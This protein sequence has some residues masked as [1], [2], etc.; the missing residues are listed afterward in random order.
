MLLKADPRYLQYGSYLSRT[1]RNHPI[2]NIAGLDF[3]PH[4]AIHR[5]LAPEALPSPG[6]LILSRSRAKWP[7]ISRG[8]ALSWLSLSERERARHYPNRALAKR[9]LISRTVLRRMLSG[10]LDCSPRAVALAD[11]A[12]GHPSLCGM[13]AAD[14][15]CI[16]VAYAGVW[17]IIGVSSTALG[18]G[19]VVPVVGRSASA[20]ARSGDDAASRN[21]ART[22]RSLPNGDSDAQRRARQNSLA[23]LADESLVPESV[24]SAPN[25]AAF[26]ADTS[27]GQ[28]CQILDL[29]MP[30]KIAA[31]PGATG[32]A[33]GCVRLGQGLIE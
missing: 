25:A 26:A 5:S 8:E 4:P 17:I 31:G 21:A 33:G 28:H 1:T 23:S 30:G 7:S 3:V 6:K 18:I 27:R 24:I 15:L 12:Y 22:T 2:F 29:P 9:Y 11:G 32:F 10:M 16:H 14:G 13:D 20:K 19:A